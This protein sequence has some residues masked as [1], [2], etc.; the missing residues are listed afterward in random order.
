MS[1]ADI[2][3]LEEANNQLKLKVKQ[4][5]EAAKKFK[6]HKEHMKKEIMKEKAK[7][8]ADKNYNKSNILSAEIEELQEKLLNNTKL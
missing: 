8:K 4:I 5:T 6:V 1:T 3:S 7:P 2:I